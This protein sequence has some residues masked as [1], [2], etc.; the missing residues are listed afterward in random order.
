MEVKREKK[1]QE[2]AK[3]ARKKGKKDESPRKIGTEKA[4][5]L[6]ATE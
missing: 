4:S 3:D 5:K 6:E 1:E 2:K